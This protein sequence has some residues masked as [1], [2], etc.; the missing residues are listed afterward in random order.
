MIGLQGQPAEMNQVLTFLNQ[1]K[2]DSLSAFACVYALGE[3]MH[4]A[5]H[6]LAQ[7]ESSVQPRDYYTEAVNALENY[8]L[9][10]PLR[11]EGM[12]LLSV[13]AYTFADLGGQLLLQLSGGQSEAIQSAA[14]ATLGCYDDPRIAPALLQRWGLLTPRLRQDAL[15]ALLAR[16]DRTDAVLTALESGQIA[17][18]DLSFEQVNYL[19]THR[20]PAIRRRALQLFGPVPW[21]RPAAVRQFMPALRR[22]GVPD[23]GRGIFLA[24]CAACHPPDNEAPALGPEL[25]SARIYRPE[26]LLAAILEPNADVRRDDL[27]YVVETAEGEVFIGLL[28][29]ENAATITLRQLNGLAVVLPRA[30]LQYLQAQPWSLMP[31]GLEEGLAPATDMADL[32]A[33]L[34]RPTATP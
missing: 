32:L 1:L 15:T 4:R 28:R 10:D 9:P 17:G 25:A 22:P 18:A 34:R 19:R 26:K 6:S 31:T 12:R 2:L 24:R 27:A 13:S 11:V 21:R 23:R 14:I 16:S 20:D 29:N 30:N 7:V 5:G 33:Y 8:S 3:G